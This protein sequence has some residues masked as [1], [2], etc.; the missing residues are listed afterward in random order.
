MS[1]QPEPSNKPDAPP[2]RPKRR[3][4]SYRARIRERN[5]RQREEAR[6]NQPTPRKDAAVEMFKNT[7]LEGTAFEADPLHHP[8]W[9]SDRELA[10]RTRVRDQ[11]E[12]WKTCGTAT[13]WPGNDT[14]R[15]T[16]NNGNSY[17]ASKWI[18]MARQCAYDLLGKG[19]SFEQVARDVFWTVEEVAQFAEEFNFHRVV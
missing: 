11:V 10:E 13:G 18:E 15:V 9:F 2:P 1:D 5:R 8:L 3:R 12:A 19:E 6:A 4:Q 14:Y 7:P 17:H 16:L